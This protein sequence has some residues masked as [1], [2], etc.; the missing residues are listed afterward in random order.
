MKKKKLLAS[1]LVATLVSATVLSGCGKTEDKVDKKTT[2]TA[3]PQVLNYYSS[4]EPETLDAQQISGQPDAVLANMFIEGLVR[5]SKE[6]GKYDPGVA[7]KWSLD[8]ATNTYTFELNK[9]AKW[10]DGTVVTAKDFFFGWKLA[11]DGGAAYAFMLTDYVVGAQEYADLTTESFFAG[12][13][14]KFSALVESRSAEKDK[15]KKAAIAAKVTEALKLMTAE[16]TTEFDAQKVDLWSKV[17]IKETNGNIEVKLSK[18]IPY[19][20][21][22]T[23]N[24]VYY[25]VNEAFYNAHPKDYALEAAGLNSNGPWKITE[26]KHDDNFTLQKNDEYWNKEN[27]KLDTINIKV[28]KEIATRTNLLKTGLL[29]GSKIQANDLK[30]FQDKAVLD[31]YKLQDLSDMPDYTIFYVEFNQFSNEITSNENIRK[32]ISLA[33]DR[34]GLVESVTQGDMAALSLIPEFFPGLDKSF[35]EEN[36]MALIEDNQVEKAKEA[37]KAGL[38]E[39]KLEK[40]PVQDLL[41]DEGDN[42]KKQAEKTQSD[43]KAIGIDISIVPVAWSDKLKRLKAGDFGICLSGWGPDYADVM[44]FLDLFESTNGNNYGK[45]NNPAFDKLIIDAK[46]EAD[47]KI[48]MGYLYEA[49]KILMEDMAVAPRYFRIAHSTFKNYLTGVVVRGIGPATDF[50]WASVDME[51]KT[52]ETAK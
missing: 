33:L 23:A 35:R 49:E 15:T 14:A 36:G 17:G 20:V 6:E 16:Q 45:Y 12:K 43:L 48:R 31:Q 38:A 18:V 9:N 24:P 5:Y 44:T 28:V 39:L 51:K 41:Y 52:A 3:V 50:Y 29:D 1:L 11:L 2:E 27:I 26:W 21:G 8:E 13:D 7:T 40:L 25:P 4:A 47:P 10:A 22:L 37:L 34:K 46:K 19:F 32:A 30:D 42:G